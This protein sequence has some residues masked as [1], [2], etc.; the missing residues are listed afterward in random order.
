[1][2][3]S[4]LKAHVLELEKRIE[5]EVGNVYYHD[6]EI[7]FHQQYPYI[8]FELEKSTLLGNTVCELRM[9]I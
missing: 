7:R 3:L 8:Q 1:M 5:S 6:P 4:E 2:R 9:K